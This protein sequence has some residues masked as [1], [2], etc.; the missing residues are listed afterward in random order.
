VPV[1]PDAVASF[2]Q[3]H[4]EFFEQYADVLA[5]IYIPHPH[6]GRAIPISE[7]QILTLRE[8]CKQLETKLREIIQFGEENDA[9]GEKVHR[10]ALALLT[11][12][13]LPT[14]AGVIGFNL[15]EDFAVP[16]V[17]L[18]LWGSPSPLNPP[19][20]G[21]VSAATRDYVAHLTQ[22][23]CGPHVHQEIVSELF[24]EPAPLLK[25]FSIIPL[26]SGEPFGVLALGSEDPQ[27]FYPEMGTV[28]LKRI[29]EMAATALSRHL[30][31]QP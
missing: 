24:G 27:R 10:L 1:T 26:A 21:N 18:R 22:P 16:H 14:L 19:E 2:L 15:R 3:E 5:D 28:Y 13:D 23:H 6:G 25:S 8:R 4:P 17:A 9:I 30:K 29:G 7:R 11:A 20:L 12:P 31:N